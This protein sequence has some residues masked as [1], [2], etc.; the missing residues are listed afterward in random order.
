VI[1]LAVEDVEGNIQSVD[2]NIPDT[3]RSVQINI[4]LFA[5]GVPLEALANAVFLVLNAG[6]GAANYMAIVDF[7]YIQTGQVAFAVSISIIC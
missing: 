5:R 3:V 6:N 1:N 2:M 4:N 7:E